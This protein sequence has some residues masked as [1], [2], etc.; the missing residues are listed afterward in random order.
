M[1]KIKKLGKGSRIATSAPGCRK[2][3]MYVCILCSCTATRGVFI[4]TYTHAIHTYTR[5]IHQHVSM[6][7]RMYLIVRSATPSSDFPLPFPGLLRS[8]GVRPPYVC[9]LLARSIPRPGQ[10]ETPIQARRPGRARL[11]T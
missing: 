8:T 2:L 7:T 3:C 1:E 6:Y 4:Y 9:S 10:S 11:C 5:R